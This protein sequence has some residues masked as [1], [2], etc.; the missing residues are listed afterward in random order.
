M[1]QKIFTR[2]RQPYP[3]FLEFSK[4]FPVIVGISLFVPLFLFVFKPFDLTD[5]D[6]Q[7]RPLFFAGF[8]AV[9]FIL[10]SFNV[11]VL[12]RL[13]PKL[14]DED[15]WTVGREMLWILWLVFSGVSGAAVFEFIQPNCPFTF[16]QRMNGNIQG[17]LMSIIPVGIIV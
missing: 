12:P 4:T 5:A 3:L 10:L 6:L 11:Y 15:R 7:T 8:G 16:P 17:F 13:L 1:F 14:F 9:T 2:L